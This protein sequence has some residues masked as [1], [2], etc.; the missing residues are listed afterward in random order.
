MKKDHSLPILIGAWI[1]IYLSFAVA[2]PGVFLSLSNV[3]QLV[4]QSLVI[5]LG[6]LGITYIIVAGGIDLSAGSVVALATVTGAMTLDQTGSVGAAIGACLLTGLV[7]GLLNGVLITRL[8]A[9]PFI[10]TL[11]S[12]L[13]LRGVAKGISGEKPVYPEAPQWIGQFTGA[14]TADNRWMIIPP[15]GWIWVVCTA[16]FAWALRY[17]TF[18]RNVVA[19]GSNETA[20]RV[21][22]V[23][24]NR[25]KV[26]TYALGGAMFGLAGLML[27]SRTRTGDMSSAMG[28]ELSMI[29]AAVIGGASLSGGQGNLVGASV[30]ALVMATINMGCN[31]V[32]LSNWVQEILTGV[33]ILVAVAVDRLR[34]RQLS[35]AG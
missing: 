30:G 1:L 22:G 26:A 14:L 7:C 32:G 4:R 13:A 33:I 24:V 27:L 16:A 19:I 6:A 21:C 35:V 17:T 15:G 34:A 23:Q 25:V 8:G 3:E 29:A 9:G 2:K 10:V 12:M 20:A 31:T 28:A 18:G 5:G 11:V